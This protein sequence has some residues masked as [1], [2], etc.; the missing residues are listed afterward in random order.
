MKKTSEYCKGCSSKDGNHCK[1]SRSNKHGECPCS[2]CLV[3][4]TCNTGCRDYF[5]FDT[6][7]LKEYSY[8]RKQARRH[9]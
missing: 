1:L 8:R 6:E 3:K 7:T 5:E 4:V 9:E 2:E